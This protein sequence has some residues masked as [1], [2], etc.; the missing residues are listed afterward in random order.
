MIDTNDVHCHGTMVDSGM[1]SS[2]SLKI[3]MNLDLETV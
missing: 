3:N 1:D 2:L